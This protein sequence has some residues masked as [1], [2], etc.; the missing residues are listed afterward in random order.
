MHKN[1]I[2]LFGGL[3]LLTGCELSVGNS[4]DQDEPHYAFDFEQSDHGWQAGFSDYPKD[5]ADIYELASGRKA[6]PSDAQKQGFM[7]SGH[8]RSDD[9]FMYLKG[10]FTGLAASSRYQANI[11]LTL[12]TSAG[13]GCAGAGGAP[14]ESVWVKFGFAE[15]EPKQVDYYLN[16]DKG[17][18]GNSGKNANIIG[19]VAA[20]GANCE[21]S[22]YV[23]KRL[24]STALTQ[25]QFTTNSDGSIWLFVGTDSGYEGKTTLYYDKID[26]QL[27]R[28]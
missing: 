9:L 23:E 19:N 1:A 18:Q 20:S 24:A 2:C 26:I 4:N 5:N 13:E 10:Q 15:T 3:W 17:N 27:K 11:Q 12:L 8:N 25:L 14:G 6:L 16:Q 7:L 28:L 21:G 22:Q